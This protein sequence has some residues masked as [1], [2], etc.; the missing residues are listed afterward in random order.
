M[1]RVFSR[2]DGG[3]AVMVFTA[4][5]LVERDT[6]NFINANPGAFIVGDDVSLPST[7]KFR[8]CWTGGT[9]AVVV[10]LPK[11]REQVL[12]EVRVQRDAALDVTDKELLRAQELGQDTRELLTKRQELRDLPV[13]VAADLAQIT[14]PEELEAYVAPGL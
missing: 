14:T 3:V 8:N 7:R 10:D 9:Q 2:A 13:V 11:A 6:Q 12:A 4:E 1:Y 5:G